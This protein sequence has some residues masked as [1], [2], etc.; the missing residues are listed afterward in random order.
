MNLKNHK[1]KALIGMIVVLTLSVGIIGLEAGSGKNTPP[2]NPATILQSSEYGSDRSIYLYIEI[3]GNV[4]QGDSY[5]S[6]LERENLIPIQSIT[7][8]MVRESGSTTHKLIVITK[9]IDRSSPLLFKAL[10]N[11]EPVNKAEFRFYRPSISGIGTEEHYYTITLESGRIVS[12]M[13]YTDTIEPYHFEE[14]SI[15]FNSITWTDEI[16]GAM[17]IDSIRD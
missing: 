8:E 17:H 9:E 3:D 2:S 7:Q 6:S 16:N 10:S 15:S 14:I 4:V 1:E 13:T 12:M 11:D 5:V